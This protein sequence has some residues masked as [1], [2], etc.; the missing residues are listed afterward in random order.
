MK[1]KWRASA[2]TSLLELDKWRKTLELTPIAKHLKGKVEEYFLKQ[3]LSLYVPGRQVAIKNMPTDLRIVL[4]SIGK[5][6]PYK[7]F[8][9]VSG[10]DIEIILIRHPRQKQL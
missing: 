6:E 3:D 4:L 9:R 10:Y 8:Y 7:V 2:V 5:S 1:V